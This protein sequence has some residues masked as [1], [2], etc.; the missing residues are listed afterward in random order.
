M[1]IFNQFKQRSEEWL[2]AR[3]GVFTASQIGMWAAE[4]YQICLTVN[5]LK[6]LLSTE[7]IPLKSSMKRDDLIALLPDAESY[8][9]LV[10]AAQEAIDKV[11][12]ESADG[13]DR[14][15][16]FDTYWTKR[17]TEMEPEAIA[18]YERQYGFNVHQVGF[19][20]HDSGHFGASPDGIIYESKTMICGNVAVTDVLPSHG[21]EL[22]CP[23]GK[24]HLRY[25]RENR[26]PTEYWMQIQ[27]SLAVT[28]FPFWDFMS[29]HPNL[30]P[31]F[32]RTFADSFTEQLTAGLIA[33]G[34]E[35][36]RQEIALAK[37]WEEW[38]A[39]KENAEAWDGDTGVGTRQ[40][41]SSPLPPPTCSPS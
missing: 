3:S 24:T 33:V 21:L 15:P 7:G 38:E 6:D 32:V 13:E 34:Q 39:T 14:P 16:D 37:A 9:Q 4:P 28:G 8:R 36:R 25:R 5:E 29:F 2:E 26:V 22:K 31:L 20:L 19:I 23:E 1:R 41:T 11:L 10:P 17:G 12:G 27:C 35:K 18:E 30:P 40:K